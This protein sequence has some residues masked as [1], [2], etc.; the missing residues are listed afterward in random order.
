MTSILEGVVQRGTATV[1]KQMRARACRSPARPARPT[2]SKDAWFVGY[3]PDLVV[4]VFVGYDT[5]EADGQGGDRRPGRRR[6]SSASFMKL[7]LGRQE[8]GDRS[9]CRPASSW[10]ASIRRP[11]CALG[12]AIRDAH[13]GS[14]QAGRGAGRRRTR[15]SAYDRAPARSTSDADAAAATPSCARH[16]PAVVAAST[17]V[18]RCRRRQR[19]P[20]RDR[21]RCAALYSAASRSITRSELLHGDSRH[22]RRTAKAGRFHHGVAVPAAEASLT[23]IPPR[24][25]SPS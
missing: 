23:G 8:A 17:E 9:A 11:A 2:T 16:S 21:L 5:P 13:H 1:V 25:G 10:S 6:R 12:A 15:S 18:E 14:V 4:G 3:S 7:A 24:A 22:A 19:R 20:C